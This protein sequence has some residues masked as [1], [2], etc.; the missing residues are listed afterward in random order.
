MNDDQAR[1]IA[2]ALDNISR[3]TER[4]AYTSMDIDHTSE[5]HEIACGLG[6]I[7]MAINRL[8]DALEN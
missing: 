5:L 6:D 4:A 7:A 1:W 2:D 8:A 3:S